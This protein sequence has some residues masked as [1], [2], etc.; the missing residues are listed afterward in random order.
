MVKGLDLDKATLT[1]LYLNE[2]RSIREI[3]HM[4]GCSPTKVRYRCIKYGIE[5]RANT[6]NRK[7]NI[8]KSVLMK[9]YLK[10]NKSLRKIAEILSCSSETVLKRCKEH[11]IPLRSQSIEGLTKK[12]LQQCYLKEGKT[13]REIAKDRGCSANLIRL[14][15]KKFGIPLRNPGTKKIEIDASRLRRLYLKEGKCMYEIAETLNCSPGVISRRIHNLG[16]KPRDGR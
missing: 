12:V 9:L 6:W 16:L 15:C 10:E 5:L 11:A 13:T 7:I 4:A 14:K 1:R 8:K 2:K 3:A